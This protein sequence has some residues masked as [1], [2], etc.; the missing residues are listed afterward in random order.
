MVSSAFGEDQP[1]AHA[2]KLTVEDLRYLFQCWVLRLGACS[3]YAAVHDFGVQ[4]MVA[5]F[6]YSVCWRLIDLG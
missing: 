6:P 3:T 5:N 4:E 1:G 2:T